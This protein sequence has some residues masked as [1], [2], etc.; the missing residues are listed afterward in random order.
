MTE[1]AY[2]TVLSECSDGVRT[3]TLNRPQCLNAMNARLLAD[4]AE[5]FRDANRDDA[6]RV[7]LFNGAGRA[8]CAG[9]DRNEHVHPRSEAEARQLVESIQQVTREIVFGAKPVVGAIHG[10]AVGG[11]FEWALNCDLAVWGRSARAFFPE[12]SLNLFVTGAVTTLLPAMVGLVKARQMLMLGER[13]GADELER[14]G[15]ACRVLPDDELA[16]ESMALAQRLA[17]QPARSLQAMKRVLNQCA[18]ADIARAL[19]LETEA[20]VEGFLDPETTRRL[21]DF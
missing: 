3:I 1:Y 6:A 17:R 18:Q 7:I 12:V 14:L 20:T 15:I 10:W 16:A 5:A 19:E 8:F 9:D 2:D 4:T 13:Y 21:K 11:G